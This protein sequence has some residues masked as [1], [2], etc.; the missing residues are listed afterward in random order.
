[1][2]AEQPFVQLNV[3]GRQGGNTQP[4][5]AGP[6]GMPGA[7]P[8]PPRH[9]LPPD[10]RQGRAVEISDVSEDL[11][12]EA[13]MRDRL[14]EYVVYRFEKMAQQSQYDE[15][16]ELQL[17][18]WDK[19]I[20]VQVNGMSPRQIAKEIRWLN[21]TS[22]PVI[23][24]K[25]GLPPPLQRQIDAARDQLGKHEGHHD[26]LNYQWVL[27]QIDH[28]LREVRP[29]K[30]RRGKVYPITQSRCNSA[31]RRSHCVSG[32]H[33]RKQYERI[34]L[35][36]YFRREPRGSAD[37]R[38]L[39]EMKKLQSMNGN[40]PWPA[41]PNQVPQ[42][43]GIFAGPPPRGPTGPPGGPRGPP[44]G[45]G[46]PPGGPAQGPLGVGGGTQGPPPVR[47]DRGGVKGPP[48]N[49]SGR[50]VPAPPGVNQRF[51]RKER[52]HSDCSSD[53]GSSYS[54]SSGSESSATLPSSV[55]GSGSS[56]RGHNRSKHQGPGPWR[57]N[58]QPHGFNHPRRHAKPGK[59]HVI[60]SGPL[61]P[62]VTG[63]YGPPPMP[64][65]HPVAAV[66]PPDNL[67]RVAQDAYN[68]GRQDERHDARA[69][70]IALGAAR[71]P[72]PRPHIIQGARP[73]RMART[74]SVDPVDF[75]HQRDLDDELSGLDHLSLHDGDST[76]YLDGDTE[77]EYRVQNGSILSEDPFR[78]PSHPSYPSHGRT[79]MPHHYVEVTDRRGG[80]P[81]IRRPF[82]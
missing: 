38:M 36:A 35:T 25:N 64:P 22:L 6:Q 66:P 46:G 12:S 20:R 41:F 18:T 78:G 73:T 82:L 13:D 23:E 33:R 54:G 45:P 3:P 79:G 24:K 62:G 29:S 57:D 15:Y 7:L 50:P 27:A 11:L 76:D 72:R 4:R 74:L 52:R 37:I 28:Q 40:Q 60:G 16:G 69:E 5:M 2:A 48:P 42:Q 59:Q 75:R 68:A 34:S 19:A 70:E 80:R 51:H 63:P 10:L 61:F 31:K 44:G 47:H 14:M 8:G 58:C 67:Q 55:T 56:T 53:S 71:A 65:P 17:P 49:N 21:Q 32:G 39:W 26:L 77:Y 9:M 1:M 43:P 81:Y 30:A